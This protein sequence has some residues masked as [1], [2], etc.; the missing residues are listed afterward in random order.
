MD[1]IKGLLVKYPVFE[2]EEFDFYQY[3][4]IVDFISVSGNIEALI[5][6]DE[7]DESGDFYFDSVPINNLV[8]PR[9]ENELFF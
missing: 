2:D 4:R 8:A 6:T 1:N 9:K 5:I 3:G 7:G